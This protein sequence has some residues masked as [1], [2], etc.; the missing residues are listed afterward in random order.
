MHTHVCVPTLVHECTCA[1]AYNDCGGQKKVL[2]SRQLEL[3]VV[4][5]HLGLGA[6]LGS[7]GKARSTLNH[8]G[9]L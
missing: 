5:S 4:M 1:H 7:S 2:D 9:I 6:K 8:Y 3:Q